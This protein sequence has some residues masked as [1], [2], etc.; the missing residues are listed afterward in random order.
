M[1]GS[2][3]ALTR[4]RLLAGNVVLSALGWA[5]P[6]SL[7]LVCIPLLVRALGPE[8]FGL[9]AFAW[10]LVGS[11]S[12][13]DL[14]VGRALTQALA[15]RAGR[16]EE[17]D[18]PALVWSAA[19]L[20][21]ALGALGGAAVWVAAPAI[22]GRWLNV[23]PGLVP[24]AVRAFRL[25]AVAV[26]LTVVTSGLR[27]VLEAGQ[28][29]RAASALRV[30]L[31]LFTFV[32]PLA[33]HPL[34]PGLV[35][36]V[37]V[38]VAGRLVVCALHAGQV[39]GRY[40]ALRRPRAVRAG[41]L[42]EFAGAAGWMTVSTLSNPILV[43]GDRFVLGGALPVAAFAQYAAVTEA[44]SKLGLV[45]SVLQP[46][47][48]PAVAAL[49]AGDPARATRLV[50]RALRATALAALPPALVLVAFAP[51]VLA[52]WLGPALSRGAAP[53][54]QLL[55]VAYFVNTCAQIPFAALQGA[56]RADLPAKFHAV[57]VPLYLG[58]LWAAVGQFGLL[59][60][61]AA[62]A[63]RLAGDAAALCV[64]LPRAWPGA[65]AVRTRALALTF[66]GG[67][68]LGACALAGPLAVRTGFAV[69]VLVGGAVAGARWL[70]T[71]DERAL[72][73]AWA[74]QRRGD[75]GAGRLTAA[76][77]PP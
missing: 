57:E 77:G 28:A 48:L 70:V 8:R 62:C 56:G 1:L 53:L 17:D 13:F 12:P 33:V 76:P 68:L 49:R 46:V 15:A 39:L 4:G 25:L 42:R 61:G 65:A 73:L 24:E 16:A 21:L 37:A 52:A 50:D 10:T 60:A 38:V 44:A 30:P 20:L 71:P 3:E 64:A 69:T 72:A 2:P 9:L 29:F 5:V 55:A 32:G 59:G 35:P 40:P 47:L 43:T 23:S 75:G 54:L 18:S 67:A 34:H 36:A 7:G 22:A 45:G 27:G 58:L 19:W 6:A 26:P 11:F 63:L 31:A 74:R 66:G 51:E 41:A 14:G